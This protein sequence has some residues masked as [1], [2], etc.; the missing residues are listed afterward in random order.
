[1][2]SLPKPGRPHANP[3]PWQWAAAASQPPRPGFLGM[4]C[5]ASPTTLPRGATAPPS[6]LRN[7]RPVQPKRPRPTRGSGP[8]SAARGP[9]G[10]GAAGG[11]TRAARLCVPRRWPSGQR[12]RVDLGRPAAVCLAWRR[13]HRGEAHGASEGRRGPKGSRVST[14]GTATLISGPLSLGHGVAGR[15]DTPP[16]RPGPSTP[17][18]HASAKAS[19]SPPVG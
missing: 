18:R 14:R 1:M 5:R 8:L 3:R 17:P 19:P 6:S 16:P 7:K 2:V 13:D 10:R 4:M 15:R 11:D 9:G 12:D